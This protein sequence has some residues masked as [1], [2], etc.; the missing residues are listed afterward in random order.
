MR[1]AL[2]DLMRILYRAGPQRLPKALGTA[3]VSAGGGALLLATPRGE[4]QALN[5][6]DGRRRGWVPRL[7]RNI[8]GS[9]SFCPP[10]YISSA[11]NSADRKRGFAGAMGGYAD[12]M[13]VRRRAWQHHRR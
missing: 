9:A 10:G 7:Q 8:R 13:G 6:A 5:A 1:P 3:L 2:V 4:L 11:G 12:A